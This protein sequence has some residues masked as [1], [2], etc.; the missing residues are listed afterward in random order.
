MTTNFDVN[1]VRD[2][3]PILKQQV[4]GNRL[5]YLDNGATYQKPQSVI[6]A[7]VES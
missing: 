4:N 1:S 7:I 5:V 3:F 6:D 2:D